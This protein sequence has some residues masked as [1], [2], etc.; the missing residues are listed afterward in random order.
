MLDQAF[1]V[2]EVLPELPVS[3]SPGVPH[4]REA[5]EA[6]IGSV[7]IN[8]DAYFDIAQFLSAGDFHIHRN[9][10][11]WEAY[12]RLA[13]QRIPIDLLT[14][15]E[16]L[17]RAG[18]LG[19]IGGSAYLT[20][21]INQVPTS[22]NAESYGR[23]V[24][25][26]SARRKMISAAN[27][28]A[29]AAYNGKT[30]IAEA[31]EIANREIT[32]AVSGKSDDA[33]SA[34]RAI[35]KVYDRAVQNAEN[36]AQGKPISTGLKTGL[37]D[38]DTLLLGIEKQE[39]VIIA[40]KTGKGKT[41]LLYDIARYNVLREVKNVAVFSLEMSEEEVMRRFLSQE[42]EVNSIK[43][44]TGAMEQGEW[45][46][47]T[48]AVDTFTASNVGKLFLSD[49]RNLTPATL[50]AKC[51]NL[52]RRFGLDLVIVDYL[53][54]LSAGIVA[55]NRTAEVSHISR[56]IKILA[57]E[58]DIPIISAAQL[59]RNSEQ[60]SDKRPTLEDLKESSGI[61]QDA[62]TV[63]FL[64]FDEYAKEKNVTE[65]IVAKRRDGPKGTV[66]LVYRPEITSFKSLAR[67]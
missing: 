49:V 52:H 1:K 57:G 47:F 48:C 24:E 27:K 67:Y 54:L 65:C 55:G 31:R 18:L 43:I 28:I 13:E 7:L 63:I 20:A 2:L 23:I 56:Q 22:L 14:L 53:Q 29:S 11:V 10:W 33:D 40:A 45:S 59:N 51:M 41:S 8:P 58:L 66:N 9:R 36:T 6:C 46:K 30:T 37:L 39:N 62:N 17:E 38:L 4:S 50:R 21:L 12:A 44:K 15:S 32:S 25:E 64:H 16:E 26:Y 35:S 3:S 61:E 42:A 19:E 5:E 60:R 34:R